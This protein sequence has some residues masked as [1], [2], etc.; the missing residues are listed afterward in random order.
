[1]LTLGLYFKDASPT[2]HFWKCL[3]GAGFTDGLLH[4]SQGPTLP[5]VGVGSTNLVQ[6]PSAEVRQPCLP[7]LD[8]RDLTI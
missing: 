6:R 8:Y 1:M 2:N 3:A 7:E 5:S 4:P